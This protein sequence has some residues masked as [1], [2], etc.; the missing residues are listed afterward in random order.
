MS[1]SESSSWHWCH[2]VYPVRDT[3]ITKCIHFV[4]LV[5]QSESTNYVTKWI[6]FVT[7]WKNR[8]FNKKTPFWQTNHTQTQWNLFQHES[9]QLNMFLYVKDMKNL[10]KFVWRILDLWF[11][12][13]W[14]WIFNIEQPLLMLLH[15]E[16]G[17]KWVSESWVLEMG[18]RKQTSRLG[19]R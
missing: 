13:R 15:W 16:L 12:R 17:F 4:T 2:E 18:F 8:E 14:A 6:Q 11:E 3:G 7:P 1:R 19:F 10:P 9:K 5:S